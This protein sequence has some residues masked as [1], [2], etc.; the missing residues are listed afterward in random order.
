MGIFCEFLFFWGEKSLFL[1]KKINSRK[2]S[3]YDLTFSF[4]TINVSLGF[5]IF[6]VWNFFDKR[7]HLKCA[8]I[9]RK[10]LDHK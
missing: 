8:T 5:G 7:C 4:E 6:S 9:G 2:L 3:N 10:N 1:K